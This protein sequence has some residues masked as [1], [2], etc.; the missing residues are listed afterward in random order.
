LDIFETRLI[1]VR[2]IFRFIIP[3]LFAAVLCLIFYL[4]IARTQTDSLEKEQVTLTQAL[5]GGAIRTYALTGR[6]PQ[7]LDELLSDYHITYDSEKFV[8]EYVPN[9]SNLLPSISV[10]PVNARK[11]RCQMNSRF[12][13]K[14]HSIDSLA[15][16]LLFAMYVL[17][18]LFLMLFGAGNYQASVKSLDTNKQSLYGCPLTSLPSFVSTIFLEKTSLTELQGTQVLCFQETI[19]GKDYCTYIY[20]DG[21][22]LKS[23]LQH[24]IPKPIFPWEPTLHS[25]RNFQIDALETTFLQDHIN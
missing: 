17:F 3:I 11:R 16:L 13:R 10:L 24:L 23:F 1:H 5:E 7:S 21:S 8:V 25:F 9:G 18:L 19:E 6:Y 2:R 15:A 22:H 14:N 12:T 20:F 4:G